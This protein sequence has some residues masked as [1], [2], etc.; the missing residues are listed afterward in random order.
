MWHS[1][2]LNGPENETFPGKKEDF[3]MLH[4]IEHYKPNLT[5]KLH[6]NT[7]NNTDAVIFQVY[8]ITNVILHTSN[9][10]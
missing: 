6:Y 4:F 1:A 9:P 8:Y 3:E 5:H 2:F 7:C 10:S